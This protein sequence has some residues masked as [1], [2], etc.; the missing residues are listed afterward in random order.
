MK[1]LVFLLAALA[2]LAVSGSFPAD[3]ASRV[4]LVIGINDYDEVPD[5]EK[6]V[7]DAREMAVKLHSLGF[8]VTELIDADRRAFNQ[9]ISAFG[10]SLGEGDTAFVHFSGHGVEIDGENYLLPADVPKPASGQ[11][12]FV[13]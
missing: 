5:L 1:R 7:G 3:A 4:A 6:A 11:K 8:Q 12:G 10:A 13:K 2:V 9:A